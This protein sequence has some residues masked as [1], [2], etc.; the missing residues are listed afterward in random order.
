MCI[1]DRC[2]GDLATDEKVPGAGGDV[3]P[4]AISMNSTDEPELFDPT[5]QQLTKGK[6]LSDGQVM[7]ANG[8]VCSYREEHGMKCSSAKHGFEVSPDTLEQF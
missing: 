3:K 6:A 4:S 8:F 7:Y 2:T 1:R 5:D